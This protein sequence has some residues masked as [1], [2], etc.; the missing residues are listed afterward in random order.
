MLPA[1]TGGAGK[2]LIDF[3]ETPLLVPQSL[4]ALTVISP[5]PAEPA[6]MLI[7]GLLVVRLL[8]EN[9]EGRVQV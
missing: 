8:A 5:E 1:I 2:T 6:V 4:E 7:L 3:V 9:P